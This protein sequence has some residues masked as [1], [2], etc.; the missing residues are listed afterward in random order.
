MN[1]GA[2]TLPPPSVTYYWTAD[3]AQV[4]ATGRSKQY[5]L[6]TFGQ[7]AL[8]VV[9]LNAIYPGYQCPAKDSYVV[10]V[11]AVLADS[12]KVIYWNG[13]F[14]CLSNDQDS[15]QWG[16]DDV[17]DLDSTMFVGQTNQNYTDFNPDFT[18]KY[19]WCMTTKDGCLQKSYFRIPTSVSTVSNM[20]GDMRLY[21][22]PA[23]QYV[24][25]EINNAASG[26]FD[27]EVVDMLGRS[28]A[29][30]A[31]RDHKATININDFASGVYFVECYHN[32]VKFATA[33]FV[34]N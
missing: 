34:K 10:N 7:T 12:P 19:Y 25:I 14:I 33:K 11:S 9:Y 21:P 2:E 24:N 27:V 28:L 4:W 8:S 26:K 29:T 15:Y 1:F 16:Y 22:N 31:V 5:S 20:I 18:G 17:V 30:Q 13:D 3:F 32:G 23:E 6:V